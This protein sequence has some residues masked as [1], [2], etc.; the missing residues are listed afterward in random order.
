MLEILIYLA[1]DLY[2]MLCMRCLSKQKFTYSKDTLESGRSSHFS[3]LHIIQNQ[4]PSSQG[5]LSQNPH[6]ASQPSYHHLTEPS[7]SQTCPTP[8]HFSH[9]VCTLKNGNVKHPWS[10]PSLPPIFPHALLQETPF[11]PGD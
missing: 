7:H 11:S 8:L 10:N 9:R 3:Q 2:K 1:L 4:R 5:D 6:L